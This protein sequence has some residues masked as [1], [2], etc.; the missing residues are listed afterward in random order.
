M[1]TAQYRKAFAAAGAKTLRTGMYWGDTFPPLRI[2]QVE[3]P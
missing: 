2:V 1:K 3:K